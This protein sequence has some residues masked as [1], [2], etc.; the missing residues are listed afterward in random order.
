[1][2]IPEVNRAAKQDEA[3]ER[4]RGNISAQTCLAPPLE[5]SGRIQGTSG[6]RGIK[7]G[8]VGP[9]IRLRQLERAERS[10]EAK[11][12]GGERKR[13]MLVQALLERAT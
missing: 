2:P 1:L 7:R 3:I 4:A 11:E 12:G 8:R 10:D 6:T 5:S 13:G 9:F